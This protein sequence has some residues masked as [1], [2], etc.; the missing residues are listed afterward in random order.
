[1][2]DYDV[3]IMLK[4]YYQNICRRG[5]N[6]TSIKKNTTIQKRQKPWARHIH[7]TSPTRRLYCSTS[8]PNRNNAKIFCTSSRM[9]TSSRL[10]RGHHQPRK[11]NTRKQLE[12]VQIGK[13]LHTSLEYHGNYAS[14]IWLEHIHKKLW[15]IQALPP[16]I[17]LKN[18]DRMVTCIL[19]P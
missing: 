16:N 17:H 19:Q 2:D 3:F 18:H 9:D 15:T 5:L 8:S 13:L 4:Y 7:P 14:T 6:I 10:H 12:C 11:T 1:M